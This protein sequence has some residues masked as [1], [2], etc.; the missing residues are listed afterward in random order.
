MCNANCILFGFR[1]LQAQDVNNRRILEIGSRSVNG[2][3][4]PIIESLMPI[5]YVG[6]DLEPG[7]GVDKICS[8]D[9]VV[10]AFGQE[11][12]DV[13]ISTELVEHV[14][15]W[16]SA[17][18]NIKTVCR[19]GG[20]IVLTTRSVGFHYHGY[21][22]DFWRYEPED[23]RAIFHDMEILMLERDGKDSPGVFAKIR[24]PDDFREADLSELELYSVIERRRIRNLDAR[25]LRRFLALLRIRTNIGGFHQRI[26]Q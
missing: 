6:V 25:R 18:S 21:P 19:R 16:R 11:S 7:P 20:M 1:A 12:F 22:Y 5:E 13:V 3:L 23:I 8:V 17:V 9:R 24:K 26:R 10:E 15:D 14:L 2:S 4:R